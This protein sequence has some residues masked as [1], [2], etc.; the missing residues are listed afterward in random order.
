MN[1]EPDF[2]L[3]L[4]PCRYLSRAPASECDNKVSGHALSIDKTDTF[5]EGNI[6]GQ[7]IFESY[8]IVHDLHRSLIGFA[9][10]DGCDNAVE[11]P[12]EIRYSV[13]ES[14]LKGVRRSH[15]VPTQY[16]LFDSNIVNN[17]MDTSSVY[18]VISV[19]ILLL[20]SAIGMYYAAQQY[21]KRQY[22]VINDTYAPAELL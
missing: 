9:V 22:T 14:E 8:Y 12:A 20:G 6:L 3:L 19:F 21:H 2:D 17:I 7:T 13:D 18:T 4:S 15:H 1:D 11:C 10:I 5:D 16:N